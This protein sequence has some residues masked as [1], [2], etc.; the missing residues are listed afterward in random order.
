M[1]EFMYLAYLNLA[2]SPHFTIIIK[3]PGEHR[4]KIFFPPFTNITHAGEILITSA[5][6]EMWEILRN[7]ARVRIYI[8]AHVE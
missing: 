5:F 8:Y 6:F 3:I 2:P 4:R 7:D 1:R